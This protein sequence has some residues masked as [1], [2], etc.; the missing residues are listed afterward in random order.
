MNEEFDDN[1]EI[2]EANIENDEMIED[3][4]KKLEKKTKTSE[5]TNKNKLNK[6]KNK[7]V[8]EPLSDNDELFDSETLF[9]KIQV[10]FKQK[11]S[12]RE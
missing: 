4:D 3:K 2:E 10:I 7:K 5:K 8:K 1:I 6:N 11:T 12:F 9:T